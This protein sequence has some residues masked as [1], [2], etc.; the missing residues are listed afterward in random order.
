MI[1]K[2]SLLDRAIGYF[3]PGAALRRAQAQAMLGQIRGYAAGRRTDRTRWWRADATG[4]NAEIG[5]ALALMRARSRQMVRD[6]PYAARAVTIVA[7]H[8]VGYGIAARAESKEAQ[9]LWDDW[10]QSCDLAGMHDFNGLQQQA[11]RS[12]SEAGEA[13]V[14]LVPLTG[15]EMRARGLRVPLQIE[16]MEPDFL[17]EDTGLLL[18]APTTAGRV[19]QGVEFDAAGRRAAYWLRREHPGEATPYLMSASEL[20]RVPASQILHLYRAQ[21]PGQVRGV[22]DAA[23]VLLRLRQLD[24]YEDAAVAQAMTQSLL[25]VFFTSQGEIEAPTPPGGEAEGPDIPAFDLKPGM[26]MSLPPGVEPK[27]L[28]PSG[29][30]PFEP[31][32]LHQL[33]AIAAG[34]G[35]TY[36]QLTG[37]LRQANY[38]SLRAGKIEFKRMIEQDQWLL[39]IPRLCQPVG[40]AFIRAAIAAGALPEG[41]YPVQWGPPRMEMID[42]PKEIGGM[43]TAIRAGLMDWD[44]AV[45]ELGYDPREQVER[46]KAWNARLDDAG[47]ILT[48]DARRTSDAG[49]AQDA[50]QN[51]AIEIGA[52]GASSPRRP[53]T[54]T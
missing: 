51:A 52:N 17:P 48:T 10:V 16:V 6:N 41:E 37:D 38:S 1:A 35:V 20:Q 9:A 18:K 13:L 7:A 44:Q 3:A 50:K 36:D 23:S 30:G 12:R 40:D 19:V 29:A 45:A 8:Q 43:I 22:P 25:G 49:G 27:F 4:P 15:P 31:F 47:L 46:I 14:R 53:A 28:Q 26:T 39:F 42:A 24:D 33:M 5:P 34:W 2:P 11:A 21:R 32:A 54:E